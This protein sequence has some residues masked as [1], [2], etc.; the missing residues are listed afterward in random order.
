AMEQTKQA[1]NQ[2]AE[3]LPTLA[4][5]Q[6]QAARELADLRH[7][8]DDVGRQ[9]EQAV[10]EAEKKDPNAA[11]TRE[12]LA[13]K[14]TDAARKQADVAERLGKMDAPNQEAR[15]ERGQ[16]A[17]N[18]ALSDL[19]DARP[20]D[21]NASQQQARRELERLQQA[22]NGQKPADEQARELAKRQGDLAEEAKRAA[23]DPKKQQELQRKQQQLADEAWAL[24]APEAPQR[25]AEAA[26]AT[27]KAADQA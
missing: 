15:Q 9:A 14:L 12:D 6:Q 25:K 17:Q 1:L 16:E 19:M 11:K 22:L 23:D 8:Q 24:P 3:K 20:Q 26:E 5:R 4:Q 27:R 10:R 18:R 7:L 2:L 13:K 21:V